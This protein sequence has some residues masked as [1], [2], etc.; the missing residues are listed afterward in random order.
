V[1]TLSTV[2]RVQT[3][4]GSADGYSVGQREI[5]SHCCEDAVEARGW[6]VIIVLST[7]PIDWQG[8]ALWSGDL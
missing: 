5:G 6:K 3:G 1:K 2:P 7:K 8:Y 4:D